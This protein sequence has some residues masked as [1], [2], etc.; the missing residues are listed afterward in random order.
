VGN[1]DDFLDW[2]ET[3]TCEGR[4]SLTQEDVDRRSVTNTAVASVSDV[5]SSPVSLST[6]VPEPK[7]ALILTNTA[8]PDKYNTVDQIIT[9]TY[10]V[11]NSGDRTLVSPFRITDDRVNNTDP[12]E[13][14]IDNQQLVPQASTTCSKDYPIAETDFNF[15]SSSVITNASASAQYRGQSIVS[16]TVTTT[17]TCPY[18]GGV[19][20][21]PYTIFRNESLAQLSGWYAAG[22]GKTVEDMVMELQRNNCMGTSTY[23]YPGQ[24]IYVPGAWPA[25]TVSG[26]IRDTERRPIDGVLVR[27]ISNGVAVDQTRTNANGRYTLSA[28]NAGDYRIFQVSVTLLPGD[29]VSRDFVIVPETP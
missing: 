11:T 27:L 19:G 26:V 4:Y 12:F 10:V 8:S 22:Q 9:Y 13:C 1:L 15:G 23:T 20:W 14:S 18:P 25:A 17:I 3:I 21:I 24:M 5:S 6:D 16:P 2:E 29:N 28:S 7:P